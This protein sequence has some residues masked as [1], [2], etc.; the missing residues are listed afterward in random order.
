MT[1]KLL[2]G[3]KGKKRAGMEG[4]SFTSQSTLL[5]SEITLSEQE[6]RSPQTKILTDIHMHQGT[7]H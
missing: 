1:S 5:V 6:I 7:I 4:G 2:A 3:S